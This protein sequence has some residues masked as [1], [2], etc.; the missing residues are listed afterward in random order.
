VQASHDSYFKM[1]CVPVLLE[2]NGQPADLRAL[3]EVS[4][5]I[6][7]GLK[8]GDAVALNP[9][10]PPGTTEDIILPLIEKESR[11]LKVEDDFYLIYNPERIYEGRAIEDIEYRYPAIVAGAGPKSLEVGV[12]LYSSVFKKGIM[13][14]SNIRTAETEKL[15]EGV[16]R[17]VNIAL[18]NE[19]AKFCEKVGVNFWEAMAAANSQPFC[20]IHKPGVGVGGACIP[21]YLQ[22][23]IDTANRINVDCNITK[24]GRTIN[25]SM[26]AYCVQ[27]TIKL[28]NGRRGKKKDLTNSVMTLLGL[29]F[30]GGVSDTRLSPTY[31]VIEGKGNP[32]S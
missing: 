26:A 18:A 11:G 2:D 13:A 28:L 20:H 21:V 6:S 9:S 31:K 7:K 3:K 30:R 17:D 12:K 14:I 15:F 5:A 10:V 23:I 22:F 27:Q 19:L 24:L 32:H 25:Y 4:L 8:K 1:I 16:Y 29:A